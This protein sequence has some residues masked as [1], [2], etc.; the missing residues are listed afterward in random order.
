MFKN[1]HD[2]LSSDCLSRW[3]VLVLFFRMGSRPLCMKP[4][5]SSSGGCDELQ[6][7][8]GD[9]DVLDI[10]S[11]ISI[12]TQHGKRYPFIPVYAM[13]LYSLEKQARSHN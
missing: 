5:A 4:K 1:I 13:S 10:V 12:F 2:L 6:D 9:C 3:L 8:S 11:G 7:F